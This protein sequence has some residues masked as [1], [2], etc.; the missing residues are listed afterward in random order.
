MCVCIIYTFAHHRH[1]TNYTQT[2]KLKIKILA[3]KSC[4]L[5]TWLS[6][7]VLLFPHLQHFI[8]TSPVIFRPFVLPINIDERVLY[9]QRP[10]NKD[11]DPCFKKIYK[12]IP[13]IGN[14][15]LKLQYR[16]WGILTFPPNEVVG[17]HSLS[18]LRYGF[19]KY[20]DC[21][22]IMGT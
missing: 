19:V 21:P 15:Q 6:A 4:F 14:S 18:E 3:A 17:N 16:L 9:L 11:S 10:I 22:I 12:S 8:T 5:K 13:P 7:L 2:N 1:I 20:T